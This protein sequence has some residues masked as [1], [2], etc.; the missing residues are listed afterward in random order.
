MVVNGMM[1]GRML[2]KISVLLFASAMIFLVTGTLVSANVPAFVSSIDGHV[3]IVDTSDG[4][5]LQVLNKSTALVGYMTASVD[6]RYV[7]VGGRSEIDV[8]D[9]AGLKCSRTIAYDNATFV[10]DMVAGPDDRLYVADFRR[11]CI[12]IFDISSGGRLDTWQL[13]TPWN[14]YISNGDLP[15]AMAIS[16]DG[17]VLYVASGFSN[18]DGAMNNHYNVTAFDTK[19]GKVFSARKMDR[20][21]YHMILSPDGSRLYVS[22][23]KVDG[24]DECL[25]PVTTRDLAIQAPVAMPAHTWSL[26]FSPGGDMLYQASSVGKSVT[27]V[28]TGAGVVVKTIPLPDFAPSCS[29][30]SDGRKLLVACGNAG[31]L[32]VD[33]S[34][35][36]VSVLNSTVTR[37]PVLKEATGLNAIIVY[38]RVVVPTMNEG[39]SA[40]PPATATLTVTPAPAFPT[41]APSPPCIQDAP[42]AITAALLV[43]ALFRRKP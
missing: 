35:Y 38:G 14:E 15:V 21:I 22:A 1:R 41:P 3:Y 8:L 39:Q 18:W 17:G 4:N 12:A 37:G 23:S 26:S 34:K 10:M 13:G 27:F 31:L 24:S 30:T 20:M 40:T 19:T 5:V 28:D 9:V 42:V 33:T 11:G 7:F 2:L 32:A 16:P 29:V 25:I 43:F 6:G 36:A